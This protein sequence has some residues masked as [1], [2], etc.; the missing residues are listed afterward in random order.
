MTRLGD[1]LHFGQLLKTIILPKCLTFLG[2]FCKVVEI[3][4]FAGE[5][6]LGQLLQTFGDFFTGHTVINYDLLLAASFVKIYTHNLAIIKN[7]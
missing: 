3:F 5:I 6:I 1:L 7:P 2:N 4:H